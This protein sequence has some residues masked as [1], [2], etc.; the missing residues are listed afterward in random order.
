M[1]RK[2]I[3]LLKQPTLEESLESSLGDK[4]QIFFKMEKGEKC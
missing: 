4:K 1:I 2:S 3:V